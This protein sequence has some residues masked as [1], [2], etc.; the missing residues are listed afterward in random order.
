MEYI[1]DIVFVIM[2]LY[3]SFR[4]SGHCY[5]YK[6]TVTSDRRPLYFPLGDD[7]TVIGMLK[8]TEILLVVTKD[9]HTRRAPYWLFE[10]VDQD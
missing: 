9:G 2:F 5:P 6:A 10:E 1:K 7:V 4:D 8:G 3:L